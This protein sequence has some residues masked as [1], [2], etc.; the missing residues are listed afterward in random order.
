MSGTIVG[1]PE[2]VSEDGAQRAQQEKGSDLGSTGFNNL[3]PPRS[4]RQKDQTLPPI[5]QG[6]VPAGTAQQAHPDNTGMASRS[7]S[8]TGRVRQT[9]NEPPIIEQGENAPRAEQPKVMRTAMSGEALPAMRKRGKSESG[10]SP[11]RG[12]RTTMS[13]DALSGMVQRTKIEMGPSPPR[14]MRAAMSGGA[15]SKA[16]QYAK[17]ETDDMNRVNSPEGSGSVADDG[18][19]MSAPSL[20]RSRRATQAGNSATSM[21]NVQPMQA[22]ESSHGQPPP[23]QQPSKPSPSTSTSIAHPPP[24]MK[25]PSKPFEHIKENPVSRRKLLPSFLTQ[26]L[27][28]T[29]RLFGLHRTVCNVIHA[30][31]LIQAP[32]F[33]A[34]T[35]EFD[36]WPWVIVYFIV[37][38]YFLMDCWLRSRK[39]FKNRYGIAV[40]DRREIL[41]HWFWTC[42]GWVDLIA[43]F[44]WDMVVLL[45]N[46]RHVSVDFAVGRSP[47]WQS[48][49]MFFKFKLWGI[50]RFLKM[51]L[52]L[53]YKNIF[54]ASIA[55]IPVPISRLLKTM[56]ILMCMGHID[57]CLFWFIDNTLQPPNRWMDN[58]FDRTKGSSELGSH[59]TQFSSEYLMSYLSAL[60]TLV[61][62]LRT[63]GKNEEAI[64]VIFEFVAGILVYGTVFGNIHS[65]VEML[66]HTAALTA[67]EETHKFQ[68]D[69]LKRYMREKGFSPHLQKVIASHKEIQWRRSQGMDEAHLF[70]DI[71]KSLQQEIK[72]FLYLD[73]I[74]KVPLFQD[75][76]NAFLNSVAFKMKPLVVLHGMYIFRKNDEGEEMFFIKNGK[77]EICGDAGNVFATLSPGSFFGE[78]A[79]FEDTKRTA[80]ARALGDVE[81]CVLNKED[82]KQIMTQHP[83]IAEQI[84]A[85]IRKRRENEAKVK[86]EALAKEEEERVRKEIASNRMGLRRRNGNA[87]RLGT[88]SRR[89]MSGIGGS[90]WLGSRVINEE[91]AGDASISM[92]HQMSRNTSAVR[93]ESVSF[94]GIRSLSRSIS[95]SISKLTGLNP[96]SATSA[97][98]ENGLIV[99][100]AGDGTMEQRLVRVIDQDKDRD[101]SDNV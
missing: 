96:A 22:V 68:M 35:D 52:R 5:Y 11:Q 101:E 43:S 47:D 51:L 14:D 27:T 67:A 2:E 73:M 24:P 78:I 3:R 90:Q 91:E 72:N 65:I 45:G 95:A 70:D 13:G 1:K 36:K 88:L 38:L 21:P 59:S 34:W 31:T 61:L 87:S 94:A 93:G 46:Y 79:L 97:T 58:I 9:W 100:E 48:D 98:N 53:P 63:V 80:S 60:A 32:L 85:T 89:A 71:P 77:V 92:T 42:N 17:S 64:Y 4:E 16:P 57:A 62:K 69:W 15:I 29:S 54:N 10:P 41:R 28:G 56:L 40:V 99:P 84:Q 8:F 50:L 81:L 49:V 39:V 7:R 66:D 25:S 76:D 19:I 26:P 82:F 33:M 20:D 83:T 12:L 44:P 75:S 55:V 30:F 86:A 18:M 6:Q 37:D 74:K 23:Q